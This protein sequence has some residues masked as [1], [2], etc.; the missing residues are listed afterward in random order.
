[1]YDW[2]SDNAADSQI[3]TNSIEKGTHNFCDDLQWHCYGFA[4]TLP[5]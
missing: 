2:C 1:M 3:V 5:A 4:P